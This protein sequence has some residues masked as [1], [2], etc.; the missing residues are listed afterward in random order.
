MQAAIIRVVPST[1]ASAVT[2]V[3]VVCVGAVT[4]HYI[5][6]FTVSHTFS[7]LKFSAFGGV[8]SEPACSPV[9]ILP[10]RLGVFGE[11][12]CWRD[13]GLLVVSAFAGG[14]SFAG[15]T[16]FEFWR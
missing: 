11:R 2:A 9:G 12:D 15:E 5:D 4:V 3:D 7:G 1:T 13:V 16:L 10:L 8:P 14:E 6:P